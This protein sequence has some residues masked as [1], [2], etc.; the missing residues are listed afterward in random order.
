MPFT[1]LADI[2]TTEKYKSLLKAELG[3][4][5]EQRVK[6]HYFE[7]VKLE[8]GS[9]DGD[10][11][12]LL[13]T[14]APAMVDELKKAG[15]YK[16][17]GTIGEAADKSI[18]YTVQHGTLKAAVLK[19]ALAEVKTLVV[20][21]VEPAK[22]EVLQTPGGREAKP[23]GDYQPAALQ[24]QYDKLRAGY[25]KVASAMGEA[26]KRS[27]RE[28]L[29]ATDAALQAKNWADAAKHLGAITLQ[30]TAYARDAQLSAKSTEAPLEKAATLAVAELER[31]EQ[32]QTSV[33]DLPASIKDTETLVQEA[34]TGL[35]NALASLRPQGAPVKGQK[36]QEPR[37]V[38]EA[39]EKLA[40]AK[41]KV[42]TLRKD[43]AAAKLELAKN[44]KLAQELVTRWQALSKKVEAADNESRSLLEKMG[45]GTAAPGD[46]DKAPGLKEARDELAGKM[47]GVAES[48]QKLAALVGKHMADA[49][50]LRDEHT[51]LAKEVHALTG[52]PLADGAIVAYEQEAAALQQRF[53]AGPD[54]RELTR[55][56]GLIKLS[57]AAAEW[58]KLRTAQVT[59][60][61]KQGIPGK[62]QAHLA[63]KWGAGDAAMK[64]A[65]SKL[66]AALAGD[67]AVDAG[68]LNPLLKKLGS[69]GTPTWNGEWTK[70]QEAVLKQ[71][72][73]KE[74]PFD[75]MAAW[76]RETYRKERDE[77][78][79]N[80]YKK[81][82]QKVEALVLAELKK[83]MKKLI[84]DVAATFVDLQVPARQVASGALDKLVNAMSKLSDATGALDTFRYRTAWDFE[85]K[86]EQQLKSEHN[87]LELARRP[88]RA[89]WAAYLG[90]PENRYIV[91][92]TP[93]TFAFSGAVYRTHFTVSY[94]SVTAAR[95]RV[96]GV[97]AQNVLNAA[98][99]NG[100]PTVLQ[101]HATIEFPNSDDNPHLYLTGDIHPKNLVG[102][103]KERAKQVLVQVRDQL[104]AWL[105]QR[106]AGFQQTIH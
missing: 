106:I 85:D 51:A 3:K 19:K 27:L 63:A 90:I 29:V 64:E 65:K 100:V 75:D 12:V 69:A 89:Q 4:L 77:V 52:Q 10:P 2:K 98:F 37:S 22:G 7:K 33:T 18:E 101:A 24:A 11:F 40:N 43:L 28:L 39:R 20:N 34:E 50:R 13:G 21:E 44:P 6:Y 1:K 72:A 46:I 42:E 94:D 80:E 49:K 92:Q 88:T 58:L 47:P 55:D 97:N 74:A 53:D 61:N 56:A 30:M 54:P 9:K 71:L 45:L 60:V 87:A 5:S 93:Q 38:R 78:P 99:V 36:P 70:G 23:D 103:D 31:V 73:G 95:P 57:A 76:A 82:L 62:L 41:L 17:R 35:K 91:Q 79:G 104:I 14:F 102:D 84:A 8:D 26:T 67:P 59:D 86:L 25:G 81:G 68:T 15:E 48:K 32:A 105:N 83:R 16:A 96:H 66:D